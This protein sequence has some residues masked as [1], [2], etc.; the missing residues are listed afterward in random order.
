MIKYQKVL[1]FLL[2]SIAKKDLPDETVKTISRL[3]N[4]NISI[5]E[6]QNWIIKIEKEEPKK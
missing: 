4:G 6:I 5:S 1:A 2:L 3:I